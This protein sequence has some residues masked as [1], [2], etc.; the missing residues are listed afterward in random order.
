VIV[1]EDLMY[2]ELGLTTEDYDKCIFESFN[3]Y[4]DSDFSLV[5]LEN[6]YDLIV[7]IHNTKDI[8]TEGL[9]E[10]LQV[11]GSKILKGIVAA[12]NYLI[13]FCIDAYDFFVKRGLIN[14]CKK[15][16]SKIKSNKLAITEDAQLEMITKIVNISNSSTIMLP[17]YKKEISQ[18]LDDFHICT[19]DINDAVRDLANAVYSANE[20]Y[21]NY[22]GD[23]TGN[24]YS[25][26]L[27]SKTLELNKTVNTYSKS[28]I[29]FGQINVIKLT[30]MMTNSIVRDAIQAIKKEM[31]TN[32]QKSPIDIN[33]ANLYIL[34]GDIDNF[35]N[36]LIQY[37]NIT[38]N[39]IKQCKNMIDNLLQIGNKMVESYYMIVYDNFIHRS[40]S[41]LQ[42]FMTSMF[43]L[44]TRT[45]CDATI[46]V[47]RLE[48]FF[49]E[50]QRSI[51]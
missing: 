45:F 16:I 49:S 22:S 18:I 9:V 30:D 13:K 31:Y 7:G 33:G 11:I 28:A 42:Q 41:N 44:Q 46:V 25:K 17:E 36:N 47:S 26:Y 8:T 51:A 2:G 24:D 6:T 19:L 35:E 20:H 38:P 39:T 48:R 12:W 5:E 50:Q 21:N 14:R 10:S 3:D 4:K 43:S 29:K 34:L 23:R 1:F 40:I 32:D 37:E 27:F 15:A